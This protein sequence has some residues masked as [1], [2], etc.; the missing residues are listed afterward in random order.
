[1]FIHVNASFDI[2]NLNLIVPILFK[3]VN[4]EE[5]KRWSIICNSI[6]ETKTVYS[7]KHF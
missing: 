7:K 2:C 5:V 1:M 4:P 3:V 6:I